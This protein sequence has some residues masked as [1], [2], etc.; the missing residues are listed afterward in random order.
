MNE[1]LIPALEHSLSS[2]VFTERMQKNVLRQ[3]NQLRF[4][5]AYNRAEKNRRRQIFP[6]VAAATATALVVAAIKTGVDYLNQTG[7]PINTPPDL[8]NSSVTFVPLQTEAASAESSVTPEA[9]PTPT[10]DPTAYHAVSRKQRRRWRD[11]P[12][13]TNGPP[14]CKPT[15]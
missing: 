12:M 7:D 3:V 10:P 8:Y 6:G 11:W 5:Q 15:R 2:F 14:L 9:T 1:N 4:E 13:P